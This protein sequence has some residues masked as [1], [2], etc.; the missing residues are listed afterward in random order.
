MISLALVL[1]AAPLSAPPP[2]LAAN[3]SG[4]M[5]G[6][7]PLLRAR[8]GA[9]AGARAPC[10]YTADP[11][12][13]DDSFPAR[14]PATASPSPSRSA[15]SDAAAITYAASS[16]YSSSSYESAGDIT[17]G[18]LWLIAL[19]LGTLLVLADEIKQALPA[20]GCRWAATRSPS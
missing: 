20:A 12:Y 6:T 9:R 18:E 17:T 14:N 5:G 1:L 10:A 2:A 8:A 7:L 11:G 4:R 16:S 19:V 13:G 15:A 3:N